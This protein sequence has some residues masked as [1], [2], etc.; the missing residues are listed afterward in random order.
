[1]DKEKTIRTEQL[2][3][4]LNELNNA[5][6]YTEEFC[7]NVNDP[8][9]PRSSYLKTM[10]NFCNAKIDMR[11]LLATL[12]VQRENLSKELA[13]LL[14]GDPDSV[15][16]TNDVVYV[17]FAEHYYS[18]YGTDVHV[19]GYC[20]TIEDAEKLVKE[21]ENEIYEF[22]CSKDPDE[23][24]TITF[25]KTIEDVMVWYEEVKL[26]KMDEEIASYIE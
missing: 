24:D 2:I 16:E 21:V 20:N 22:E 8:T 11:I 4:E 25:V 3:N 12:K 9:K 10:F 19:H 26:G 14:G 17:V 23:E 15:S 1:M 6:N 7:N 5:I 13:V 18:E